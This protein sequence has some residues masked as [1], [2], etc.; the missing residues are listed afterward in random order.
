MKIED[1]IYA[2]ITGVGKFFPE[3]VVT[4]HDMEKRVKT[5]HDWIVDRT[6]IHERRFAEP[7][8]GASDLA[9]PAIQQ[10]MDMAGAKPDEIDCIICCTITPDTVFP[11]ASCLIQEKMG[12]TNAW[13]FDLSAAC[14]GWVY[15]MV[16][17]DSLIRAG[18]HRKVMVV[19]V[20]VMTAILNM[21]DRNT[22][23]LFGDGAGATLVERLPDGEVGI[24]DS[25][26]GS[27][28]AGGKHLY[29]PAGGSVRPASH[30][31]VEA[32]E[33]YVVQEGKAVF[34]A[35]VDGMAKISLE[36]LERI[37]ATGDDVDLFVPHQA[38]LR[39]IDYARKK[40]KLPM[41]KVMVTID[42]YGNTTAGTIPTSLRIAAEEK[43]VKK[44][45]M[46]LI[47]TFGAGFTW[48]ASALRWSAPS[49]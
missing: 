27:D 14:S 12:A 40:A 29:M 17:A 46:V 39:I 31:T 24:M 44:G 13:A 9:M 36:V 23:V 30:E 16:V 5:N 6:G 43:R 10:A 33:H 20:D 35:A 26:L 7:G 32:G 34:R 22:C 41:S 47:S 3:N 45:D 18:S 4:N 8:T 11:S 25:V 21:N 49:L 38:N 42:K 19:G 37:G 2:G 28:G 48:G 1:R 15:G